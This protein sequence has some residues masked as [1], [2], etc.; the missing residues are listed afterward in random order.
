MWLVVININSNILFGGVWTCVCVRCS[1]CVTCVCPGGLFPL[2]DCLVWA[3]QRDRVIIPACPWLQWSHTTT[4]SSTSRGYQHYGQTADKQ[5]WGCKERDRWSALFASTWGDI[6]DIV[7]CH[8]LFNSS[9]FLWFR[10]IYR[11]E[12]QICYKT[13]YQIYTDRDQ[14]MSKTREYQDHNKT[15]T[16]SYRERVKTSNMSG[17]NQVETE[18]RLWWV[19]SS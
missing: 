8:E 15:K 10:A 14:V 13:R 11:T 5:V 6:R 18:S 4:L 2:V 9:L 17:K 1:E 16:N 19:S 12:R 3:L 7:S